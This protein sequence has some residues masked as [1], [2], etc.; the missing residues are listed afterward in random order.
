MNGAQL[1]FLHPGMP[2]GEPSPFAEQGEK[3]GG[4]R[5]RGWATLAHA[6]NPS[7]QPSPLAPQRERE[8]KG[9]A[10]VAVLPFRCLIAKRFKQ[11]GF[12]LAVANGHRAQAWHS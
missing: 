6:R 10:F 9:Y 11:L 12:R 7:P 5:M 8:P 3:V 4:G 2:P 1:S